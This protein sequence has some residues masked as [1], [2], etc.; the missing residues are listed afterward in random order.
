MKKE[1]ILQAI[2]RIHTSTSKTFWGRTTFGK[3]IIAALCLCLLIGFG[4]F[5]ASFSNSTVTEQDKLIKQTDS[6][7][8]LYQAA[9]SEEEING[10]K[11]TALNYYTNTVW[12]IDEINPTADSNHQY[13]YIGIE[14]EYPVGNIINFDVTAIRDGEAEERIIS[15]ARK[16]DGR[17]TVVNVQIW[18]FSPWQRFVYCYFQPGF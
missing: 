17:W 13:N 8:V 9:L 16:E 10:A 11:T 3:S 14:A 5:S 12:L 2:S 6:E 7:T 18:F 1:T 15:V 4:V